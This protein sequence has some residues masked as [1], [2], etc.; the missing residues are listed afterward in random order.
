MKTLLI[1]LLIIVAL[2]LV[3]LAVVVLSPKESFPKMKEWIRLFLEK[4]INKVTPTGVQHEEAQRKE[5]SQQATTQLK[6]PEPVNCSAREDLNEE[7][8]R[9][10]FVLKQE[11]FFGIYENLYLVAKA[12]EESPQCNLEDWNTRIQSLSGTPDLK[13]YWEAVRSHPAEFLDFVYACGVVRDERETIKATEQTRY[14]YFMLDGTP[15]ETGRTYKVM[16]P[17]WTSGDVIL[18]KGIINTI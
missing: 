1:V 8:A 3:G 14:C 10:Q 16:Q 5:C 12:G 4:I 7:K 6:S 11:K 13:A 2:A 18:E 9:E 15:I 17:C